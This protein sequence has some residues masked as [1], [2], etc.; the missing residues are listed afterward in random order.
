[1]IKCTVYMDSDVTEYLLK[2]NA[3]YTIETHN[4]MGSLQ[5][6]RTTH[7]Y[8]ILSKHIKIIKTI[9]THIYT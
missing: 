6:T 2:T 3:M 4:L 5:T 1:M 9:H 7:L 8:S